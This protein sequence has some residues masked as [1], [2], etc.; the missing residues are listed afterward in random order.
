[1]TGIPGTLGPA[2]PTNDQSEPDISGGRTVMTQVPL[3]RLDATAKPT[4]PTAERLLAL[5]AHQF[6][7][8][9]YHA[10]TT[11][12]LAAAL[13]I[14]KSSLYYHVSSKEDLLYRICLES[15]TSI[16]S[17]VS[18]A[19]EGTSDPLERVRVMITVHVSAMI[20]NR[21]V[22][23]TALVELRALSGAQGDEVRDLRDR[24]VEVIRTTLSEAQDSGQLSEKFSAREMTLALLNLLNWTIFWYRPDGPDTVDRLTELFLSLFLNGSR[25]RI[26]GEN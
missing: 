17:A 6:R 12:E 19:M 7:T 23:A 21:D 5:A 25:P 10:T 9:G 15:L 16:H 1:M 26:D 8:K 14:E 20:E 2:D 22:H 18:D 13:G 11:R 4:V 24:Y 3:E